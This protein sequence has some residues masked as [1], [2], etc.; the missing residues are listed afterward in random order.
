[1]RFPSPTRGVGQ[2]KG[3]RAAEVLG[4]EQW[5]SEQKIG[6][7]RWT[8]ALSKGHARAIEIDRLEV[9]AARS[10]I[11]K[12]NGSLCKL[13]SKIHYGNSGGEFVLESVSSRSLCAEPLLGL[14][15][16]VG[17]RQVPRGDAPRS[18]SSCFSKTGT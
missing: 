15:S 14:Q 11:T 5:R 1:M 3:L 2:E 17:K 18:G 7:V 6:K 13:L 16:N 8:L 10:S 9:V 12:L 4:S